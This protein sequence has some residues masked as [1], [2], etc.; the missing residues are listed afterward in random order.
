VTAKGKGRGQPTR[1]AGAG[2]G[3]GQGGGTGGETFLVDDIEA[4]V[5]DVVELEILRC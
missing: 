5:H 4:G 1:G 3:Q 2:A